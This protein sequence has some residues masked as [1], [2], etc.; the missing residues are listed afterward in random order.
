M[1]PE[2]FKGDD[3]FAQI[4]NLVERLAAE[5]R[6]RETAEAA[7]KAKSELLATTGHELRAPIESVVALIRLLSASPLDPAQRRYTDMLAQAARSLLWVIDDIFDLTYLEAGR[8]ELDRAAFDLPAML[9]EVGSVLQAHAGDK[10]LTSGVDIGASCPDLVIADEA[11]I[12]QVLMSLIDTALKETTEGSV[13]LH[14]S[15]IDVNGLWRLRFDV[16]NTG[17]GHSRSE[18][19]QLFA[20]M[21]KVPSATADRPGGTGLELAI[22]R[23][24]A[25]LMGGEVG[26]DSAVGKGSLYWFTLD[27]E[28]VAEES[29]EA[30]PLLLSEPLAAEPLAIEPLLLS[31]PL[32]AELLATESK[33][34]P[35]PQAKLSGHVLVVE[36][37]AVNRMLIATYLDEFGVSHDMVASVGTAILNL[38][39]KHYDAVLMDVMMPDLDGVEA[40]RRIRALR[41]PAA[42]VP[43]VALVSAKKGDR[44][45]YLSAGMDAYVS[46]PIRGRELYRVLAPF[47]AKDAGDEPAL[48][49]G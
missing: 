15:A 31:E 39:S 2:D 38:A 19:A 5:R 23:K 1:R 47:L 46:K 33:P 34:E 28:H 11:R 36:D 44:G 40:A 26:C 14:A 32:A 9:D 13:R 21:L 3:L 22:A 16:T 20:P 49:A 37:N 12:R 42:E 6:L 25:A 7:D 43:I 48:L 35:E 18:R 27:A 10:G 29:L 4:Q 45:V 24:L 41:A 8:L 17:R 30:E